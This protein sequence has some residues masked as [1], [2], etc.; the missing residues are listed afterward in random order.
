MAETRRRDD[1]V[2]LQNPEDY[3]VT[4]P[5]FHTQTAC[6]GAAAAYLL[7]RIAYRA[8][9]YAPGIQEYVF[10]DLAN[11]SGMG[12]TIDAVQ[13][14]FSG[15]LGDLQELGYRLNARRVAE[16]TPTILDWVKAG[17]GYR[18]AL[19]PTTY[20]RLHPTEPEQV[21]HAVGIT[22]DRLDPK[23]DE[24]LIMVDPWPGT[25]N[26]ARDRSAIPSALEAAHRDHKYNAI[27]FYWTGWS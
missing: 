22:V 3:R 23:K 24:E 5:I 26:G 8:G 13:R 1:D 6:A 2:V 21:A 25:T 17:V 7:R 20:R 10:F 12:G 9:A 4:I 19:I 15:R 18:G 11:H 27:I 14:W 16:P